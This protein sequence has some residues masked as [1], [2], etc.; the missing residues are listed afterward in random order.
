[1]LDGIL[2]CRYIVNNYSVET[3]S[4][5]YRDPQTARQNVL[6]AKSPSADGELDRCIL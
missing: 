3:V 1:M 6:G 4:D 2:H 5:D